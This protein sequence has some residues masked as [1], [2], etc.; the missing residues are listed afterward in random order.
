MINISDRDQI[1]QQNL[2]ERRKS[3]HQLI[4]GLYVIS[5]E[6]LKERITENS[7][8]YIL[9][10]EYYI[11]DLMVEDEGY[12]I[13]RWGCMHRD[14]L[15]K[16]RPAIYSNMLLNGKLWKYLRFLQSK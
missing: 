15:K 10:G 7:I 3:N 2:G 9:T 1:T 5:M 4:I 12:M 8:D 11:P 6:K 16:N 14:Y 13:G